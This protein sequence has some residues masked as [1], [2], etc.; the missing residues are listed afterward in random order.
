M[1]DSP[2]Y[3]GKAMFKSM[4]AG[5]FWGVLTAC[6]L[7]WIELEAMFAAQHS[8]SDITLF[9]GLIGMVIIG[10][11]F[12]FFNAAIIAPGLD[13][14]KGRMKSRARLIGFD[15]TRSSTCPTRL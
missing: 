3:D 4:L 2:A 6:A 9:V 15:P 1:S 8:R 11:P 7:L 14:L 12:A 13:A 10:A 5:T